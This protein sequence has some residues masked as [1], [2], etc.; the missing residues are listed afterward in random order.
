MSPRPRRVQDDTVLDAAA[1]LMRDVGPVGFTVDEVA[2]RVGVS[3]PALLQRFGSKRAL[4]LAVN[5]REVRQTHARVMQAPAEGESPLRAIW[6]MLESAVNGV[7]PTADAL[8]NAYA[9]LHVDLADAHRRSM[10]MAQVHSIRAGLRQL[11][12]AAI[13]AGEVERVSADTLAD[14][15]ESVYNGALVGWVID[16]DGAAW[17]YV[18]ARLDALMAPFL[19][20]PPKRA[21]RKR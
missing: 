12:D 13:A 1:Q 19:A 21:K 11:V 10:I 4:L 9:F 2:R 8:A 20:A 14:L 16:R 17:P 7:A 15:L 6:T 3:G 5:E 18:R